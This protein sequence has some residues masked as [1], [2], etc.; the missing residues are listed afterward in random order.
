MINEEDSTSTNQGGI[1]PSRQRSESTVEYNGPPVLTPDPKGEQRTN[2]DETISDFKENNHEK[3]SSDKPTRS[4]SF[5]KGFSEKETSSLDPIEE[6]DGS[7]EESPKDSSKKEGSQLDDEDG[8]ISEDKHSENGS[9]EDSQLDEK[10]APNGDGI[11]SENKKSQLDDMEGN[12]KL[13]TGH[14][15]ASVDGY[16]FNLGQLVGKAFSYVALP[17]GLQL[18][19]I[20]WNQIKENAPASIKNLLPEKVELSPEM[21]FAGG[22]L[23]GTAINP[24]LRYANDQI[25]GNN[26][27]KSLLDYYSWKEVSISNTL[28]SF[29]SAVG[30]S[31]L[32]F[33]GINLIK[34]HLL[35]D[36]AADTLTA[37]MCYCK[38][39]IPMTFTAGLIV[40]TAPQAIELG[41]NL[42]NSGYE[43]MASLAG[44]SSS[45]DNGEL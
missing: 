18:P 15:E 42:L 5:D 30:K 44:L 6:G 27:D 35:S 1:S 43:T 45:N 34:S 31:Y 21:H 20:G 24:T 16:D 41:F 7:G 22:V 10:D 8:R 32:T 9:E 23:T 3:D 39:T 33:Y 12:Q 29:T 17:A 25:S 4:S 11:P 36:N 2:T 14:K 38:A 26:N 28:V 40:T 37:V 13:D 19:Q